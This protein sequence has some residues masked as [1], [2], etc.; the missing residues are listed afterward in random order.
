MAHL[1][2]G[3][4]PEYAARLPMLDGAPSSPSGGWHAAS[5]C[6]HLSELTGAEVWVKYEGLNPRAPSRIAA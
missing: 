5:S 2:S 4:I 6:E 1:W 3:V